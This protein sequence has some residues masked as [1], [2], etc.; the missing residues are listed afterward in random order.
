MMYHNENG[1]MLTGWVK[2]K[3]VWYFFKANGE[4]AANEWYGGYWLNADGSWT[5]PYQGSWKQN[6]VG[7]WFGDTSG[8]A[9]KNTTLKIA[10]TVCLFNAAGYWEP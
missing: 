5:Y 10:G 2:V 8:W 3:D 7:W 4:M 9:A 1:R 6:A